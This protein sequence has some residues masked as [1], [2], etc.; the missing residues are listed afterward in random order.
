MWWIRE[1]TASRAHWP[2]GKPCCR[3]QYFACSAKWRCRWVQEMLLLFWDLAINCFQ[4]IGCV[5]LEWFY[6]G[7]GLHKSMRCTIRQLFRWG[8]RQKGEFQAA[9]DEEQQADINLFLINYSIIC[10]NSVMQARKDAGAGPLFPHGKSWAVGLWIMLMW[11]TSG[12]NVLGFRNWPWSDL[13]GCTVRGSDRIW[14]Y[15]DWILGV[16]NSYLPLLVLPTLHGGV[17]VWDH[18]G[19]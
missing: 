1:L 15:C 10:V 18:P 3:I 11:I 13:L 9:R 14:C 7:G 6:D 4:L 2:N 8:C 17:P 5:F 12:R 19:E 16:S